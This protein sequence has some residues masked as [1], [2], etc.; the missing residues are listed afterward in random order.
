VLKIKEKTI[1]MLH[2]LKL[3][4]LIFALMLSFGAIAGPANPTPM[5]HTQADG[6]EI[7]VVLKG[8]EFFSWFETS[9]GKPMLR[10]DNGD[11]MFVENDL[12][13]QKFRKSSE[14]RDHHQSKLPKSPQT[15]GVRKQMVVLVASQ[16]RA[17]QTTYPGATGYTNAQLFDSLMNGVNF[18]I[19]GASGSV[20]T[21]FLD[22]SRGQLQM[23]ST[24][25][26]P[27]TVPLDMPT[28][29][30]NPTMNFFRTALEILALD[31]DV[32]FSEFLNPNT[33]EVNV[34]FIFAGTGQETNGAQPGHIWSHK[35]QFSTLPID[36]AGSK[37][38]YYSCSPEIMSGTTAMHI[39]PVVHE[40]AHALGLPDTYGADRSGAG[41]LVKGHGTWGVMAEGMWNNSGKT[42]PY[43][44]GFERQLLGWSEPIL[45][46]SNEI[47]TLTIPPLGTSGTSYFF[48]AKNEDGTDKT[49]E[50]FMFE[51][52]NTNWTGG[53]DAAIAGLAG[54]MVFHIDRSN[55][56][57]WTNNRVNAD[58]KRELFRIL[59]CAGQIVGNSHTYDVDAFPQGTRDSITDFSTPSLVSWDGV[60][61]K[62]P[63]KNIR[64]VGANITLTIGVDPPI[65]CD[66]CGELDCD[67][68]HVWCDI[69]DLYDCEI[70]HIWCDIC[71]IWDCT[72]DHSNV[73]VAEV[74][75]ATASPLRAWISND[76]LHIDG[77]T[78]GEIYRIYNIAGV[79][80]HQ[81][82]ATHTSTSLSVRNTVVE[83]SRNARILIIQSENKSV[84]IIY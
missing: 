57:A 9:N 64:R 76:V 71:E 16:N 81:G 33:E 77:L 11:L 40:I 36:I 43:F 84:K 8:D 51:N 4:S 37:F 52:R 5:S 58:S 70:D 83:R 14:L 18:T 79:L 31:D 60:S 34:H 22:N 44:N 25:V 23:E 6:T 55:L 26:G 61:S 46:S 50:F 78:I 7:T 56:A 20:K 72:E 67:K 29:F 35:G 59:S 24:I 15:T 10:K 48:Y 62:M 53:W 30:G 45:I 27:I 75:E 80:V 73:S 49:D 38:L 2:K 65:P 1:K 13:V 42:P 17:F 21:Y 39:A 3:F 63:L 54:L 12:I 68:D 47:Q 28:G 19:N 32:N 66:I 69:C 82:I 74:L 41:G